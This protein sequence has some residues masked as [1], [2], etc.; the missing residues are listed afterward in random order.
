[1]R[2]KWKNTLDRL[3]KAEDHKKIWL[4]LVIVCFVLYLAVGL[5]IYDDY[6]VS[7]DEPYERQTMWVNIN[8]LSTVLGRE[9]MGVQE[10]S[11][12]DDKYYGSVMQ[13]PAVVL[14][15]GKESQAD[16]Y[17]MRHLYTFGVCIVGYAAFYL[18]AYRLLRSRWLSLLGTLMMALAPRF[19]AE[20]FYNI[21]DMV[22]MA[23]FVVG[24]LATVELLERKLDWKW[25]PVFSFAAAL[26]TVTRMPGI[27]LMFV[28][29]GYVWLAFILKKVCGDFY[30]L[31]WKKVLGVTAGVLGCFVV[32]FVLLLPGL[33][34]APLKNSIE[35]FV[36]F[37]DL[38]DGGGYLI[39]MGQDW[40]GVELPWYYVPVWM[41]ITLPV[42][43]I[44]CFAG[45]GV[46]YVKELVTAAKE[47]KN[48][49]TE[50]IF[51]NK[52]WLWSFLLAFL[53]WVGMVMVGSTLYNAWRHCYFLFA[54]LLLFTLFGIR[55]MAAWGKG[56]GR[57]VILVL[58]LVGLVSQTGWIVR[59]H[60][61]EMVYFN[62]IGRSQAEYF[63]RD[64]SNLS[65]L[66]AWRHIAEQ[67]HGDKITVGT[68]GSGL[69]RLMLT[70][71]E[72]QRLEFSEDPEYFIH[73]Y[74]GVVGNDL[75][76]EGYE[77]W[78]TISVD[79]YKI[80]TVFKKQ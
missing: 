71:D 67:D 52:Y 5:M 41:L 42:W 3:Q 73:T 53:P 62:R 35:F 57:R 6:S 36:E 4:S 2:E 7:T 61:Y 11:T 44:L 70:A 63:D 12:Y 37:S 77:E 54:P 79:G 22:F 56:A 18:L 75:K 66:Y 49:W 45:A 9:S 1:M 48:I 39:F 13:M 55:K 25:I 27:I 30:G 47:K 50:I 21:K 16:I 8:Y 24:M 64:Y 65:E 78:H 68:A 46:A 31:T 72:L 33:W 76:K 28:L 59:N 51:E 60:P 80:A 74:R 32:F 69:F 19:F 20:Q 43:Y 29:L 40:N 26:A 10:L 38:T 17:R 14:E 58:A 34:E 15:M 23:V